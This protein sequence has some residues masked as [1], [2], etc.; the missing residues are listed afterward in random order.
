MPRK[1]SAG[2]RAALKTRKYGMYVWY[3]LLEKRNLDLNSRYLHAL[4]ECDD[5]VKSIRYNSANFHI[6]YNLISYGT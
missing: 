4:M 5:E 1:G 6:T 3:A 2:C